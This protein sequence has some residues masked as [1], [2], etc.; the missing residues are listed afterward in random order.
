MSYCLW[1]VYKILQV[2]VWWPARTLGS[3][4]E[5]T[6]NIF[7]QPYLNIRCLEHLDIDNYPL[8]MSR[9]KFPSS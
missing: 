5:I 4:C 9:I 3:L 6:D 8:V 1:Y 2:R 7:V